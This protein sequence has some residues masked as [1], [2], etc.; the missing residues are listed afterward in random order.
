MDHFRGGVVP[1][2]ILEDQSLRD[3]LQFEK[4]ILTVE[5]KLSVFRLLAAAGIQRVQVGSFVH[6]KVVPQMA[7]TDDLVRAIR[8]STPRVV[9]TALVL[10][11]KGLERAVKCGLNHLSMS[12]S[13][14][15]SHSL[16]NVKRPAEEAFSSLLELVGRAVRS[17]LQV[18]AG[19]QCAFGCVYEGAVPEER[20]LEMAVHLAETGANEIDLADTT[21]MANPAQVRRL[22]SRALAAIPRIP[23]SIHLHDTRGLGLANM[24]AAYESGVGIFDVSAGGLGGCPFVKG[25]SGNVAAEDAVNLF[26]QIGV[27][28]GVDLKALCKA[29]DRYEAILGRPL[30]GRMNRVIKSQETSPGLLPVCAERVGPD[31]VDLRWNHGASGHPVTV[32]RGDSPATIAASEPLARVHRDSSVLLTGLAADRPHFFRL[33]A[34]SGEAVIVG[35]RR[36]PVEGAPNFRDLGGYETGDGRRVKW[37]QVFRSSNLGRL[38][39]KGLAFIG[40]LGIRLVCDLRTEAESVKLPNRFPDTG[41]VLYRRR[42]IQHAGFEPTAVFERIRNGDYDW[43][44]EEFMLQGYIESI[45]CF[46]HVWAHLMRDLA[47]ADRRPLVFH[48]TGGKDRTGVGAALLLLALGVPRATVIDDYGLSDKFNAEVRK[49][50]NDHLRPLGVDIATVEP[51]FTAP[52]GRLQAF[53]DYL[54][55]RYG[56]AVEYFATK[57]GVDEAAIRRLRDELLE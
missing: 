41:D 15:N 55:D 10:N 18:R 6:P 27:D 14:S 56:S 53:L 9:V 7:D 47:R 49:A 33:V 46:P 2:I 39:D 24:L 22:V 5:E 44:S 13:A 52:P 37:G 25:A 8:S 38:T 29:V 35:E 43:I 36:P 51:Y 42:S 28:T 26:E 17:G 3:G 12:S 1:S 16:K 57:A 21:G 50:I 45:E 32:F 20:V 48:C 31:S 4:K 40:R 30:P 19:V 23:I 34:D 54:T 11:D